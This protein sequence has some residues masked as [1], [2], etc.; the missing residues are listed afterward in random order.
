MAAAGLGRRPAAR[1]REPRPHPA[2]RGGRERLGSHHRGRRLGGDDRRGREGAHPGGADRR[3]RRACRA[4]AA[5]PRTPVGWPTWPARK[6]SSVRGVMGYEGHLMREPGDT[7]ADLVERS[8][9][10]A[11]PGGRRRRRRH[12]LRWRHRHLGHQH[13]GHGAP[14]RQLLPDGHRVHAARVR[15]RERALRAG[16]G[17]LEERSLGRAR[18]RPQG[19]RHGPR[20]PEGARRRRLLVRVR[21][22]HHLRSRRGRRRWPWATVCAWSPRTS[23]PRCRSTSASTSSTATR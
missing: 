3:H 22:A 18:R 9:A 16:H 6:G 7:K 14:G 19:V 13:L 15:L 20:R 1:Q 12:R 10:R 2:H 23:T 21:R 8:M 4:A 5:S 17:D 11:A